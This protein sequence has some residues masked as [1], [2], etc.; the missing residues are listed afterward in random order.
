M[1]PM[2]DNE[3]NWVAGACACMGIRKLGKEKDA[4]S[5]MLRFCELQLVKQRTR[6][7]KDTTAKYRHL[8]AFYVYVAGPEEPGHHWSQPWV[9]YGTE[10]T[11][12]IRTHQLG[13]VSTMGTALNQKHHLSEGTSCQVWVWRPNRDRLIKWWER[14]EGKRPAKVPGA[15]PTGIVGYW[16]TAQGIAGYDQ[17]KCPHCTEPH[18]K[19]A[20][21]W[22]GNQ[23]GFY[24]C[25]AVGL[26]NNG[27][28]I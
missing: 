7:D 16:D 20:R 21:V 10:F 4:F 24:Y 14:N 22:Y 27:T 3:E 25:E 8:N 11:K 28:V 26:A 1:E 15:L 5:A 13:R 2:N 18:L 9:K 19:G 6:F 12:F 23:D 17:F